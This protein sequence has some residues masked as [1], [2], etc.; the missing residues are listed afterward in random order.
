VIPHGGNY[1][2][3]TSVDGYLFNSMNF[4]VPM[5]SDHQ[6]IET[7]IFM[8][9]VLVGSKVVMKN[10]FFSVG[11]A[12][13]RDES[14]SELERILDLMQ[15]NPGV[16]LQING[17]TD[18]SGDADV[19]KA[20]SLKRAETVMAFLV[21]KGIVPDRLKAVGYG[22]ERPIVSN[23]DE[24]GGR[25]INRR[26]EIEVIESWKPLQRSMRGFPCGRL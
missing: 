19:N 25:E 11:Q 23:D 16:K 22:E 21:N 26:T 5:Y 18:D 8:Q 2:I 1:G 14:V 15:R 7:A 6:E 4:E 20:L 10:I 24:T 3:N 12:E 17:H 9:E 13:L